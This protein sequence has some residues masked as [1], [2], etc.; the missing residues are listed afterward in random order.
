LVLLATA[1]YAAFSYARLRLLLQR[2][3]PLF[4]QSN[5]F[6]RD[7]FVGNPGNPP[8]TYV[9]MGD[10]TAVGYG[11]SRVE[12]SCAYQ[13]ARAWAATGRYVH[14]IN[15]A[16]SGAR[17]GDVVAEQVAQ[18]SGF[19]PELVTISIGANDATHGTSPE[20][21]QEQLA[22]LIAEL[23]SHQA[24][25]LMANTPDMYQ[26][27]TLPLPLALLAGWRARRQNQALVGTRMPQSIHIVDLYNE[28]KLIYR[29]NKNLYA[30]D[31]FHP[32]EV[33]YRVWAKVFKKVL[34]GDDRSR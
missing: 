4:K 19:N 12:Q 26:V 17:L 9:V 29:G 28:G 20:A 32:S 7:Y 10:S 2:S 23:Q 27:P 33:G 14:V 11:V 22:V 1:G 18:L 8:G 6:D 5:R 13:V 31:L 24:R 34:I 16:V 3:Q 30:A 21:Y 15:I 25:V